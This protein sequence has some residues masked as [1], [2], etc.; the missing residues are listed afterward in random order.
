M[1]ERHLGTPPKMV[2]PIPAVEAQ[3]IDPKNYSVETLILLINTE[4]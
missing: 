1:A 2:P 4:R 3:E